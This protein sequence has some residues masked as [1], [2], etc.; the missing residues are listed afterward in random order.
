M[1]EPR[2]R[3]LR[4]YLAEGARSPFAWAQRDCISWPCDWVWRERGFDPMAAARGSYSG[5][6]S[7][8]RF[9]LQQGGLLALAERE[10]AVAGLART[11][12]PRSGDVGI[13]ATT[14][15]PMGAIRADSVWAL[16]TLD[17]VVFVNPRLL[18]AWE[19]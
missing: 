5:R 9:L 1:M 15:G 13:V 10:M 6:F 7:C 2:S 17:G 19:V 8:A 16:K 3:R 12:A 14:F 11:K 18:A 4:A